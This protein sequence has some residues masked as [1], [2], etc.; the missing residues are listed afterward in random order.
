MDIFLHLIVHRVAIAADIETT[1]LMV[2]MRDEDGDALQFLWVKDVNNDVLDV[3]TLRFTSVVFGVSA[4][5]FLLNA[6]IKHHIE[7]FSVHDPDL[8]SL[9]MRSVY[10]DNIS[11]RAD[12]D[13]SAFQFLQGPRRYWLRV[14]ST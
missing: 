14:A 7:Q 6:T 8:A 5:P 4:S 2:A 1:F 10:I 9:F 13:D 3:T 11:A 12:D